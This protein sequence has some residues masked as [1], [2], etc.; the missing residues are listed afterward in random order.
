MTTAPDPDP[1]A[2]AKPD[3][4]VQLLA[5]IRAGEP[6]VSGRLAAMQAARDNL[7][8]DAAALRGELATLAW[9][10]VMF[11]DGRVEAAVQLADTR[12]RAKAWQK[13]WDMMPN[14]PDR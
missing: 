13:W 2:I 8:H 9:L 5:A 11:G 7:P 12:I 10:V 6:T 1:G 4:L 14:D 3:V